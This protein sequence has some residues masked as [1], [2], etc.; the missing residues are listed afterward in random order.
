MELTDPLEVARITGAPSTIFAVHASATPRSH[1]FPIAP[2]RARVIASQI[3]W[4]SAAFPLPDPLRLR[5]SSY[6]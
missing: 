1:P 6:R 3:Y 4:D 5:G 2:V